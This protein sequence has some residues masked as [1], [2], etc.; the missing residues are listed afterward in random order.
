MRPALPPAV[1]GSGTE[2]R[3]CSKGTSPVQEAEPWG[4]V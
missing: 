2:W 1:G 3:Y 4:C